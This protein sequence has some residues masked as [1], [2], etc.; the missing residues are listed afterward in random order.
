MEFSF[1]RKTEKNSLKNY[2]YINDA[3]LWNNQYLLITY[4]EKG[5][6]MAG[7]EDNYI[8]LIDLKNGE[9]VKNLITFPQYYLFFIKKFIHPSYG[10]CLLTFRYDYIIKLWK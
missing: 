9:I 1:W 5:E 6:D 7:K 8:K 3:C 4:A 2:F 10:E